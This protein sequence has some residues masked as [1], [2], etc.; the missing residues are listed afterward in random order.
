[1]AHVTV[2]INGR[3]YRMACDAGQEDH[4]V[5]ISDRFNE[6]VTR[7]KGSFGEIGDQRLTVM[8]GILI[9]DE[10]QE[11]ETRIRG[12]EAEIAALKASRD[13]ALATAEETEREMAL[14]LVEAAGRVDEL[15]RKLSAPPPEASGTAAPPRK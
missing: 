7:L 3:A 5:K 2:S 14:R 10:M 6:Y 4:L 11:M 1:M 12:L 8:A 15:A 9:I 13:G